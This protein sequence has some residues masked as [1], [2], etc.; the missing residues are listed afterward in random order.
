M[1]KALNLT[2]LAEGVE[3]AGQAEWLTAAGCDAAQGYFFA[4]PMPPGQL[5]PL[6]RNG[7]SLPTVRD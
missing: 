4:P 1:G 6:L 5:F 2:S 7:L 3:T